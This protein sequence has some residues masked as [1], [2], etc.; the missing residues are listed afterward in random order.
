MAGTASYFIA[1]WKGTAFVT[2]ILLAT[3]V[4]LILIGSIANLVWERNRS[5]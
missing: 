5:G 1:S 4:V 2:G 3:V